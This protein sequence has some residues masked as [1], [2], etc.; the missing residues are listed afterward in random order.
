LTPCGSGRSPG[1]RFKVLV[2]PVVRDRGTTGGL[3]YR[4]RCKQRV[5]HWA[6]AAA[7]APSL[8]QPWFLSISMQDAPPAVA[9]KWL[10]LQSCSLCGLIG[11]GM[12]SI[13][14]LRPWMV[15]IQG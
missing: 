14:L 9:A 3:Q 12:P 15:L 1:L 5:D 10:G 6:S 8:N 11:N 4:R 13:R 2:A 7:F